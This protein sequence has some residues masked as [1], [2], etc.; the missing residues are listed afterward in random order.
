MTSPY[1]FANISVNITTP[2]DKIW[3]LLKFIRKGLLKNVQDQS[4]K[5]IFFCP[6]SGFSTEKCPIHEFG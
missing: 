4:C 2:G 6:V 5:N 1:C 3:I